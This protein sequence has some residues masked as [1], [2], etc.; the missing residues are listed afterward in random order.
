MLKKSFR[1]IFE[2]IA[3]HIP[4]K[5]AY[6]ITYRVKRGMEDTS[7]PG[8]FPKDAAYILGFYK[9]KSALEKYKDS[10]LYYKTKVSS[11]YF[12]LEKAG[13]LKKTKLMFPEFLH[14]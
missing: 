3:K 11:L 12:L 10:K 7:L 5:H 8:G 4:P 9:I 6:I 14:F 13:Y 1:E 2:E